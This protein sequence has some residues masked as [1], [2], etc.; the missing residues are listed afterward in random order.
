ML[1]TRLLLYSRIDYILLPPSLIP[2]FRGYSNVPDTVSDHSQISVTLGLPGI[3]LP[4]QVWRPC[5]DMRSFVEPQGWHDTDWAHLDWT[6][7]HLKVCQRDVEG[8]Y[9]SFC[10]LY[11]TMIAKARRRLSVEIPLQQFQGRSSPKIVPKAVHAPVIRQPRHGETTFQV[12]DAPTVLRQRIRQARRIQSLQGQLEHCLL[13]DAENAQASLEAARNTWYAVLFSSGFPPNFPAFARDNM[14]LVLPKVLYPQDLPLVQILHTAMVQHITSWQWQY[15]KT[16]KHRYLNFLLSDWQKGGRVH[17]ATIRPSPKPEIALLEVPYPVEVIRHRH[18]K[19]SP[20]VVTCTDPIPDG[21]AYVQYLD[22]RRSIIRV[23]APHIW[24]DAPLS[25]AQAKIKIILLKPTGSLSDIHSM[26][27]KYW[28]KFWQSEDTAQTDRAR[29]ILSDFPPINPMGSDISLEE[30]QRALRKIQVDKARGPDSW[31]PWDLK[32]LPRPFQIA[33]TSLFNL[34]VECTD[35]PSSLTAATV[36]MLSKQDGAF[37]IEHTRP[38]TVLSMIYRVWSRVIAFKFVHH[39][40]DHL[41]DSIQGNRPGS[42]SKWVASYIQHQVEVALQQGTEF[43]V[44]SLDLTKAYNLLSRPLLRTLAEF[45]GVPRHFTD[46]Y[47]KFLENLRRHFRVHGDL[48]GPVTSTV[49][50]PE[51]CAYAVYCMLQLNWLL[52]IDVE[53]QQIV[54]HSVVFINYV[55]N[56]LFTSYRSQLL[57]DVLQRV[58]HTSVQCNYRISHAKTWSSSTSASVRAT[59]KTWNLQ[60]FCP[61]VCEHRLELGM[62]MKFSRRMSNKEVAARWDEGVLRMNKLLQTGWCSSRKLQVIRRGIFPQ[63][64]ASCETSHVSLSNFRRLRGK[65]NIIMH[66]SKTHS[67]H[68]LSPVFTAA[69]DYEPFLYVFRTRLASLRAMI[70][71]FSPDTASIWMQFRDVDLNSSPTRILRPVGCFLW[72]CQILGW[73]IT[74]PFEITTSSGVA[75]HLLHTPLKIWRQFAEQAWIDW[76]ISKAKMSPELQ[77][78]FVPWPTFKSLWSHRKIKDFP[79]ALKFRTLGILSGSAQAQ[80]KGVAEVKCDFC[81][82]PEAGHCHLILRCPHTQCLRDSPKFQSLRETPIFTRCTEIPS[83][84]SPLPSPT[85]MQPRWTFRANSSRVFVFTDGSAN[86]PSM[87]NIRMSSWAVAMSTSYLSCP[88]CWV[89][90]PTPGRYHDISRAETYAVLACLETLASCHIYCDNQGVVQVMTQL[91]QGKFDP[92]TFRGHPNLDL[93]LRIHQLLITRPQ[94]AFSFPR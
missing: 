65:L 40:K 85:G 14:G 26:T 1:P 35:W 34:F 88:H 79:L 32:T 19:N 16:K 30:V 44:A 59:M 36:A 84:P 17:F 70:L 13:R 49:G 92:F 47:M 57:H 53:K 2:H 28:G 21:V 67:S 72:S 63:I 42:S 25:A 39:V 5:R 45:F 82:Q 83:M 33:L 38:I 22:Q 9:K 77:V 3:P 91:L 87:P 60:G 15:A 52:V 93:W 54:Q 62:V 89:S 12:D 81:H 23:E 27:A 80:M 50:V 20:V 74:A 4:R 78:G 29:E 41:P 73:Q 6:G 86:P 71:S 66:G 69:E 51:G 18:A 48:S 90:G 43:S 46:T 24:L 75:L 37:Q 58:H 10:L 68:Y 64:F 8:A 55:D 94:I 31:S 56:W 61:S 76:A 7:F 11:E